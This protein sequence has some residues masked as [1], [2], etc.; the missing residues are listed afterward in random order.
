VQVWPEQL[1]IGDIRVSRDMQEV[2]QHAK[3][4][5]RCEGHGLYGNHPAYTFWSKRQQ[6]Q[7]KRICVSIPCSSLKL[8]E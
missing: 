3:F 5:V 4:W 2:A 8:M 1:G 6:L 7:E